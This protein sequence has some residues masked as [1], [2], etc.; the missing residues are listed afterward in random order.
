[1]LTV[2]QLVSKFTVLCVYVSQ[3][4]SSSTTFTSSVTESS[5]RAEAL[6]NIH[7]NNIISP[8]MS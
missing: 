1:M 6:L 4:F 8:P 3:M 7:L 5:H 2:A